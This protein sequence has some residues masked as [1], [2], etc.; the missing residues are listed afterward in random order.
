[1]EFN[2]LCFVCKTSLNAT[3]NTNNDVLLVKGHLYHRDCYL[4]TK[5][6]TRKCG[7]KNCQCKKFVGLTDNGTRRY[8]QDIDLLKDKFVKFNSKYYHEICF[9]IQCN[10]SNRVLW[11]NARLVKDKCIEAGQNDLLEL[12]SQKNISSKQ[13]EEYHKAALDYI[14][15]WYIKA[16]IN[17]FILQHYNI[18]VSQC[19]YWLLNSIYNGT[20]KKIG[21]AIPPSH[22]LDMWQRQIGSLDKIYLKNR[23]KGKISTPE[24][25]LMY[26][27]AILVNKYDSYLNWLQ[28]QELLKVE[29]QNNSQDN[30]SQITSIVSKNKNK[31]NHAINSIVA[32]IDEVFGGD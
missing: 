8:A 17:K 1:M 23:S 7:Y 24:S 4:R 2:G 13:I 32:D 25:R 14:E 27:I 19:Y 12:K 31:K 9:D 20:Y 28:K 11:K 18:N 5:T 29:E 15:N 16:D 26:D 22:L 21:I 6:I 10:T 3:R 30:F